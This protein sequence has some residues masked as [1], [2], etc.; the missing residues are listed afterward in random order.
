MAF[1][2]R[3][4]LAPRHPTPSF[5]FYSPLPPVCLLHCCVV[6]PPLAPSGHRFFWIRPRSL[7]PL[8]PPLTC[9]KND[10]ASGA[11]PRKPNSR[12]GTKK[13]CSRGRTF[14]AARLKI[15]PVE[16]EPSTLA[17]FC[18]LSYSWVVAP[19]QSHLRLDNRPKVGQVNQKEKC[20]LNAISVFG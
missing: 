9:S 14:N 10:Q 16:G 12:T 20:N 5:P 19:Q 1:W 18:R 4:R 13:P 15:E 3:L 2:L 6:T 7:L 17:G 8:Y 11:Y